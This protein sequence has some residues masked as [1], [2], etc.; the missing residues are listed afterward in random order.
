[1]W[2]RSDGL[3]YWGT[4]AVDRGVAR[5]IQAAEICHTIDQAFVMIETA[6]YRHVARMIDLSWS[7]IRI[8]KFQLLVFRLRAHRHTQQLS[9]GNGRCLAGS[10]LLLCS[11][12]CCRA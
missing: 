6:A 7:P 9:E 1:M 12:R 2:M 8:V 5:S 3:L 4:A 10:A 11:M